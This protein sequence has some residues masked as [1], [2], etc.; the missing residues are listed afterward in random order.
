MSASSSSNNKNNKTKIKANQN[1]LDKLIDNDFY[2]SD[3]LDDVH[4]KY[5]LKNK[6]D[7]IQPTPVTLANVMGGKKNRNNAH[8]GLRVLIDTGCSHSLI[9]K[10]YCHHLMKQKVK[11]YATGNGTL[12]TKYESKIHFSLPEFSDKKIIT[13]KFSVAEKEN[14]GYDIIL[15][16]DLLLDLKMN[17]S[18]EKKMVSWEGIEIPMRDFNKLRRHNLNKMEF[19]AII[20][21]SKEPMVTQKATDR[22]ITILDATYQKANLK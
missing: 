14:L 4:D 12:T 18:F 16:R 6:L 21:S 11:K 5:E 15:G 1:G 17:I 9:S 19:K 20:Q 10:L 8:E 2:N 7:K 3:L 22:M 13:W